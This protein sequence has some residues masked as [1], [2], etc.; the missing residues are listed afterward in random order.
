MKSIPITSFPVEISLGH[1]T[2][3]N[4]S[5]NWDKQT[6]TTKSYRSNFCLMPSAVISIHEDGKIE[7]PRAYTLKCPHCN[8]DVNPRF[9]ETL[10]VR[11]DKN[12]LKSNV[13]LRKTLIRRMWFGPP[14]MP[15]F[16][17][18]IFFLALSVFS[19]IVLCLLTRGFWGLWGF[20]AWSVY[21]NVLIAEIPVSIAAVFFL[22]ILLIKLLIR[23]KDLLMPLLEIVQKRWEDVGPKIVVRDKEAA[24]VLSSEGVTPI[25]CVSDVGITCFSDSRHDI[26]TYTAI[27][28]KRS[29]G[30]IHLK[31]EDYKYFGM[32]SPY[33]PSI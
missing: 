14:L 22:R 12:V 1:I 25:I 20:T 33:V 8:F 26:S 18:P 13:P 15:V 9:S 6:T 23:R 2:D 7:I 19:W 11:V 5:Y 30:S 21:N 24:T 29:E 10:Y 28:G 3:V 16:L 31:P 4:I 32:E 17:I 27:G